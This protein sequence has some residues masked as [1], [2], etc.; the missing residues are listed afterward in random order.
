[1]LKKIIT[2]SS[3]ADLRIFMEP[4]RQRILRTMN[5]LGLPV[6]AKRLADTLDITPSSAKHH[7]LKLV[8]IGLI[9]QHHTEQIHGITA[10]FYALVPATVSIGMSKTDHQPERNVVAQNL[11]ASVF[12]GFTKTMPEGYDNPATEAF[13]GDL[14]T[15]VVHLTQDQAKTLYDTIRRFTDE[16]SIRKVDTHPFEY[17]LILY[18]IEDTHENTL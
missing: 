10:V 9:A 18:N 3:E 13:W 1:M 16:N 5:I 11:I 4:L 12:D 7:L 17:A 15:G 8:S 6:T 2:L 14:M